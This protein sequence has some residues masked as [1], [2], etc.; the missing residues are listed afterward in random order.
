M[1]SKIV[2]VLL[3]DDQAKTLNI[4][5]TQ[6]LSA[7]YRDKPSVSS[8]HSVAGRALRTH[9]PQAVPDIAAENHFGFHQL[10]QQEG[11]LSMLCVPMIICGQPI[12]VVTSYSGVA[13]TY[14][15]DDVRLLALVASQAAVAIE[16][17]RIRTV[18]SVLRQLTGI[19]APE[20]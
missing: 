3:Y 4:A 12:G 19:G 1:D 8:E 13:R 17:A 15:D 10:A 2:S 9:L 16:Y 5:A 7:D 18:T 11:L 20:A 14:D 6:S